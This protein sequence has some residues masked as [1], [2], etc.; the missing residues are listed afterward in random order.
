ML[1]LLLQ[2]LLMP[3]FADAMNDSQEVVIDVLSS[4]NGVPRF[5]RSQLRKTDQLCWVSV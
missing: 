2:Q 3:K 1:L 4:A 5:R